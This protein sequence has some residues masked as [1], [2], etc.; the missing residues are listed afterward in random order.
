MRRFGSSSRSGRFS[1]SIIFFLGKEPV[2]NLLY[3]RFANLMFE[4]FWNRNNIASVQI[5]MAEKIDVQGRGKFYE[6]AGAIRD[7]LQ[8]HLLPRG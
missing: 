1:G 8:N 4:P 7:V 3:S 5:T 6:E 2:Q